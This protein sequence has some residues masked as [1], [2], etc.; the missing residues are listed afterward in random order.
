MTSL[1]DS[2]SSRGNN[3]IL[4]LYDF[5]S[6]AILVEPIAN[7]TAGEI[8]RA[9]EILHNTLTSRGV[10]PKTYVMDNEASKELKKPL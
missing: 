5:D 1:A 4:V 7:R 2:P 3:Y 10:P 9:W 8:K 6:N